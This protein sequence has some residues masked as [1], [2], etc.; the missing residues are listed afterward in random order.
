MVTKAQKA[1]TGRFETKV[2]D[3]ILLRLRKDAEPTRE[4]IAQRAQAAGLSLN[5]YILAAI[6]EK[7]ERE[8]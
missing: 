7:M 5:A 3:K 2:Y 6:V 1:A 4:V 8:L